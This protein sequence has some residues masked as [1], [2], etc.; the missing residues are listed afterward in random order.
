M[1]AASQCIFEKFNNSTIFDICIF[2]QAYFLKLRM[3]LWLIHLFILISLNMLGTLSLEIEGGLVEMLGEIRL[4][5]G[6]R[7]YI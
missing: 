5:T 4:H 6:K 3:L 1:V 2:R 7:A